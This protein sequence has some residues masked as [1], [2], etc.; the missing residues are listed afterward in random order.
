[1]NVAAQFS[2]PAELVHA[3]AVEVV[4]LLAEQG[5]GSTASPCWTWTERTTR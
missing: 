4:R 3:V 5:V 2:V 1:V